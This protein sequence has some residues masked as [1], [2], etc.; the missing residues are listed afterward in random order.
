[1]D[2]IAV[3]RELVVAVAALDTSSGVGIAC[4]RRVVDWK[5]DVSSFA[6]VQRSWLMREG[7]E[8]LWQ[9]GRTILI[10]LGWIKL[11]GLAVRCE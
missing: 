5:T 8:L 6:V 3:A 9:W 10:M 4:E 11:L 2:Y 7:A 1:M